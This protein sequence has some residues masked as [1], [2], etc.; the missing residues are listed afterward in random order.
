MVSKHI[1]NQ[2]MPFN[3]YGVFYSQCSHQHVLASI[4]ALFRV[5]LLQQYKMY[6][7]DSLCHHNSITI[8]IIISV[9]IM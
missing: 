7:Y 4:P 6:K 1:N 5:L 9:K 8:K 3:T 2:S